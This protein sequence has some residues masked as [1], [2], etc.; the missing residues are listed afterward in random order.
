MEHELGIMKNGLHHMSINHLRDYNFGQQKKID[1]T[2]LLNSR[3]FSQ[4]EH[5]DSTQTSD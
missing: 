2:K 5:Q 1:E 3:G 4:S